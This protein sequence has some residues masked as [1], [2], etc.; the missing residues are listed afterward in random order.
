M[1]EPLQLIIE[2][3]GIVICQPGEVQGIKL[4][5]REDVSPGE[6]LA[7]YSLSRGEEGSKLLLFVAEDLL[8]YKSLVLPLNTQDLKEAIGYQLGMLV[9]FEE[10]ELLYSFSSER[11]KDGYF[12]TLVATS[13]KRIAPYLEGLTEADYQIVGLYPAF[14]RLVTRKG[15]KEKWAL[16]IPGRSCRALLFNGQHIDERLILPA[17]EQFEEIAE[18]CGTEEIYHLQPP[19]DSSF[20]DASQLL[21]G[22]PLLKEYNLLPKAYRRPEYS[23]YLVIL[24][25]VLNLGALVAFIG[26]KAYRLSDYGARVDSE[27]A[28]VAPLTREAR[29]LR[30]KQERLKHYINEFAAVGQ[31]PDLITFLDKLTKT[32]PDSAYLEQLRMDS[33]DKAVIIQGYT[34]DIN[35][36]T[37]K[38]QEMGGAKLRSTSRRRDQTFFNI[39]VNLP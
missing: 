39:E 37:A 36:L 33:R 27:I 24:L 7:E 26:G 28:R 13:K 35:A 29:Q 32:L 18:L 3:D 5:P 22:K 31:N 25:L 4:S 21:T 34:D 17:D 11:H 12:I 8:F 6:Q 30:S 15:P 14:Q 10:E 20:L 38:L 19:V 9:P 16:V 1:S 2:S 23:K